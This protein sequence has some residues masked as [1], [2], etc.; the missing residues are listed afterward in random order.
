MTDGFFSAY[1]GMPQLRVPEVSRFTKTV[2]TTEVSSAD[3]V[4]GVFGGGSKAIE[5]QLRKIISKA[6][7]TNRLTEDMIKRYHHSFVH[8]YD[9]AARKIKKLEEELE[10]LKNPF[11]RMVPILEFNA[12]DA[13]AK[14][15]MVE[16][17]I[18][19]MNEGVSLND[20]LPPELAP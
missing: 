1:D 7:L 8:L 11:N 17:I 2:P 13:T 14:E 15:E 16:W 19:A 10:Y 20:V 9:Y 3:I 6:K 4:G 12:K 5:I 18:K